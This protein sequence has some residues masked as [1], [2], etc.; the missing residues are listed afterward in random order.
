LKDTA[1]RKMKT[2]HRIRAIF[3]KHKSKKMCPEYIK[4]SQDSTT[5]QTPSAPQKEASI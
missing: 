5:K 2:S 1:I 4:N 3:T